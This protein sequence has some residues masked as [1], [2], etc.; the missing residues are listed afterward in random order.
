MAYNPVNPNGQATMSNSE[1]VVIASNQSAIPV[2]GPLTDT[3]LR[4]AAV[5]VSGTFFQATQPVSLVSTPLPVGAATDGTDGTAPPVVLG[6][7]TGI[8]GWLRSIYEKLTG[9]IAVTGTFWQATQPVSGPLTDTQLRATTVPISGTVTA[10]GPLTD[11]QLRATA[12]PV[13][14]VTLPLPAGAATDAILTGGTAKSITRSATK[15]TTVAADVTSDATDVNTQ[16]LHVNLKGVHSVVPISDNAGSITVD[17]PVTTPV[18]IRLSDGTAAIT[19][20]PTSL[21][22]LPPLVAGT[23]SIGSVVLTAET[24]KVIGTVNSAQL[25]VWNITNISGAISLPTGAATAANQQTNAITDAQLRATAV[26]II[27]TVSTKG[28][29]TASAPLA[30]VV[31]ITSA[32]VVAANINRKG[33]VVRNTSTSGQRISLGLS[34]AVAVLDSGITLYPQDSFSMGEYDFSTG[35]VTSIASAASGRLSVQEHS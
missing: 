6:G 3:Q 33:L 25:G 17:A 13:S 5:P 2:V 27:G 24:T 26:P 19:T 21:A 35:A 31:E 16:A 9:T 29:L 28:A 18:F 8:R 15:G 22:T 12:V 23:A 11:T 1:P 4:A 20:L 10:V 14:A 32:V 30:V 34:G 7:G